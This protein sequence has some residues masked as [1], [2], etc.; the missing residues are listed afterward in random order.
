MLEHFVVVAGNC[1]GRTRE[2]EGKWAKCAGNAKA[3]V[4]GFVVM[5]GIET[6]R[7][8]IKPKS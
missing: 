2:R 8:C 5:R 4:A 3:G 6:A 7:A 1:S